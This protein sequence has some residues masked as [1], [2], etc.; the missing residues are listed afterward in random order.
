MAAAIAEKH[1]WVAAQAR[2]G[3]FR[4]VPADAPWQVWADRLIQ[5]NR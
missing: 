1:D 2:E 4:D 5:R 3:V